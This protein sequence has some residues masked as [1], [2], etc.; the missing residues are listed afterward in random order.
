MYIF[1]FSL[2]EVSSV[3]YQSETLPE[4]EANVFGDKSASAIFQFPAQEKSGSF[5][6]EAH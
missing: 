6:Y 1:S 3:K 5:P 2:S 4:L